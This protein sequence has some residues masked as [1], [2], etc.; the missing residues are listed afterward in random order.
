[1]WHHKTIM[2]NTKLKPKFTVKEDMKR[3]NKTGLFWVVCKMIWNLTSLHNLHQVH[4]NMSFYKITY[5]ST[6]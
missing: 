1:M 5:I 3:K 2:F 6:D 4:S